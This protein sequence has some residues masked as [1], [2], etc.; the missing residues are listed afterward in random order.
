MCGVSKIHIR[1]CCGAPF[2]MPFCAIEIQD[3]LN[4]DIRLTGRSELNTKFTAPVDVI[5]QDD[6]IEAKNGFE[7][8]KFLQSESGL[9][10]LPS[11]Y[12]MSQCTLLKWQFKASNK[13]ADASASS[14]LP[15]SHQHSAYRNIRCNTNQDSAMSRSSF[16]VASQTAA[17]FHDTK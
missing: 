5:E 10:F 3:R 8:S 17:K 9:F 6:I 1:L 7:F 12:D 2:F 15:P 11:E 4:V 13:V 14:C 16:A